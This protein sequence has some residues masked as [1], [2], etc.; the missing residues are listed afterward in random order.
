MIS[1][2]VFSFFSEELQEDNTREG[3]AAIP[4][5]ANIVVFRNLRLSIL[6]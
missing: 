1:G 4:V 2:V 5:E 6:I 3:A